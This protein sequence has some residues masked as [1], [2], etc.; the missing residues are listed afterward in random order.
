VD[1]LGRA[2]PTINT[3][4]GFRA[5]IRAKAIEPKGVQDYLECKFSDDLIAVR[6]A[7]LTLAKRLKPEELQREVFSLCE[8]FRSVQML[9]PC[10]VRRIGRRRRVSD[11]IHG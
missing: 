6:G 11:E 2:V 5:V 1:L 4:G 3:S 7:M 8:Q 9:R 10:A